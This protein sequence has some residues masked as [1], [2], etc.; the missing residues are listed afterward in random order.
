MAV[1][2]TRPP[3]TCHDDRMGRGWQAPARAATWPLVP[4]LLAGLAAV[5]LT[6]P[7]RAGLTRAGLLSDPP[8]FAAV[9]GCYVVGVLL[10]ARV[11]EQG[12]GW[13]FLGPAASLAWSGFTG[14]WPGGRKP[15]GRGPRGS[16]RTGPRRRRVSG[17][18]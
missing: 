6:D 5:R 7:D 15:R 13:A 16:R 4:L 2:D 14:A 18:R 10:T 8:F 3:W 1:P 11:A 12:A 9:A 17:S